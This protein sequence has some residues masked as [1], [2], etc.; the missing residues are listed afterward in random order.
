MRSLHRDLVLASWI[1]LAALPPSLVEAR[2]KCAVTKAQEPPFVPPKPYSASHGEGEFLYGTPALWTVVDPNWH[3]HSGGK[4]PFF[5]QGFDWTTE[6]RPHLAV[7]ARRLDGEG[8]LVWSALPG[9]GSIEGK[10]VEGMFMVTGIDIPSSGCW[11]I[12]AHYIADPPGSIHT[13][14]YTVLVSN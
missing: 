11:E 10:G 7:V 6:G 9:S 13:L 1:G 4:L 5:R 2:P 8:P 12:A 3:M 14:T